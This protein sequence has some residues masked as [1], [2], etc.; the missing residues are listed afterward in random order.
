MYSIWSLGKSEKSFDFTP[1]TLHFVSRLAPEHLLA[2]K[3]APSV[4]GCTS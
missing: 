1:K 3:E 4:P 2:L